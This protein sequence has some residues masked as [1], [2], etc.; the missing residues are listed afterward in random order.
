MSIGLYVASLS[1]H[2]KS[3]LEFA[4]KL[5]PSKVIKKGALIK[6]SDPVFFLMI[7]DSFI[8]YFLAGVMRSI[9][10]R[11]TIGLLFRPKPAVECNSFKLK[12]KKI[13]LLLLK[14]V[15]NV[16][17]LLIIPTATHHSFSEISDGWIYDFQ[18][19]DLKASDYNFFTELKNEM[20]SNGLYSDVIRV[21]HSRKVLCALGSQD[22]IKG[23]DTFASSYINYSPLRDIFLFAYGG[24]VRGSDEFIKQFEMCGGFSENRL[25]SDNE[26]IQLY[27]ASNIVWTLYAE[28]YD[29]A[30]GIFGRAVQLGIPVIVRKNSLIHKICMLDNIPHISMTKKSVSTI[31]KLDLPVVDIEQG[32]RLGK[33]FQNVSIQSLR[34]VLGIKIEPHDE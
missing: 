8:L 1:G 22:Q 14:K 9:L 3:Y 13:A 10:G 5:F 26:L 30:S 2:R 24:K 23:F 20:Y 19:W 18:L 28:E 34:K 25:V 27:A 17:T 29:Q 31:V 16:H 12:I 4:L 6:Y 33:H 15:T 21:K 11:K 32:K 7:E